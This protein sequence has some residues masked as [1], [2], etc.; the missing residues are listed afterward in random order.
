MSVVL[1]IENFQVTKAGII[2]LV[3]TFIYQIFTHLNQNVA[4]CTLFK[5]SVFKFCI[6]ACVKTIFN[7]WEF[8]PSLLNEKGGCRNNIFK[9][10]VNIKPYLISRLQCTAYILR[11][12]TD[13]HTSLSFLFCIIDIILP[14]ALIA[15][16]IA[17]FSDTTSY[18]DNTWKKYLRAQTHIHMHS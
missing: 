12:Y 15:T 3:I 4:S 10:I 11:F 1:S 18:T 5:Y 7:I 8:W 17:P 14:L 13:K 9:R 6:A 16:V 2:K